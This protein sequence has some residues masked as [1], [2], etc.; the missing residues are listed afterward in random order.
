MVT[1]VT[2]HKEGVLDIVDQDIPLRHDVLRLKQTDVKL[3][4][5]I[6]DGCERQM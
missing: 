6:K 2:Y 4:H 1:M 3:S 5:K